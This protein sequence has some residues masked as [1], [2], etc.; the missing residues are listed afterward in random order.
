[1]KPLH[2]A[3][4]EGTTMGF[5]DA[6]IRLEM[7]DIRTGLLHLLQQHH[8][9]PAALIDLADRYLRLNPEDA[10]VRKARDKLTSSG[11]GA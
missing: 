5:F 11:R 3:P 10:E 6:P 9:S 7:A 4:R 2:N 8:G 1:M